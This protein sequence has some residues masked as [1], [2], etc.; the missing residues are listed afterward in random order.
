MNDIR[1]ITQNKSYTAHNGNDN[2]HLKSIPKVI[3]LLAVTTLLAACNVDARLAKADELY[4]QGVYHKVEKQYLQT[5]GMIPKNRKALKSQVYYKIAECNRLLFNMKK[6]DNYY[7]RAYKN[8]CKD[9]IIFLNWAKTQMAMG[10]YAGAARNFERFLQKSQ[11][12]AKAALA[13]QNRYCR[14]FQQQKEFR[15]FTVVRRVGRRI[16]RIHVQ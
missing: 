1:V 13:L 8:G 4:K 15:F 16:S 7:G 9:S 14:Y 10:N 11:R 5:V 6:A 3:Y 12:V 2:K